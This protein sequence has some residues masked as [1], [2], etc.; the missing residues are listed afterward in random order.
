MEFFYI[1]MATQALS[2]IACYKVFLLMLSF[3]LL[4]HVSIIR[5]LRCGYFQLGTLILNT[6]INDSIGVDFRLI[7][8]LT[9]TA[10]LHNKRN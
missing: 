2:G 10:L 6:S 3:L 9:L 8:S 7:A 1:N 5:P 4:S